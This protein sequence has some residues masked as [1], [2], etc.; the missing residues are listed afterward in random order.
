MKKAYELLRI[1]LW[2][3][4]GVLLGG[5]LYRFAGGLGRVGC[6][7]LGRLRRG[8]GALVVRLGSGRTVRFAAG[9]FNAISVCVFAAVV[10]AVRLLGGRRHFLA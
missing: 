1:G 6:G 2:S 8:V 4:I 9:A 10:C 7:L 3:M 5:S